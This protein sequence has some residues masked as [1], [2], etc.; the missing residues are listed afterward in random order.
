MKR[1]DYDETGNLD[2]VA[3]SDVSLFRLEYMDDNRIWIRLYRKGTP[4][5]VIHLESAGKISGE[6]FED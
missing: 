2:D 4:D 6:C 3:V 1:V 5:L